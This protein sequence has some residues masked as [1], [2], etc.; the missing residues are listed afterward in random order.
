MNSSPGAGPTFFDTPLRTARNLRTRDQKRRHIRQ[1]IDVN[2]FNWLVW[3]VAASGFFTDSYNLFATNVILPSLGFVYWPESSSL[4]RE[5]LINCVTLAGA[6]VGQLVFGYLADRYGRTRLY[7]IELVIVIFS[8]IGV[9]SSATGYNGSMSLLVWFTAWRFVMGLGI[10]AEYPLSAVITAEWAPTGARARMMAAVFL[11]QPVGQL[12]AQLSGRLRSVCGRNMA[13]GYRR[14]RDSRS[15][16]HRVSVLIQDPGLY[17][18]DVK[19]QGDRALKNTDSLYPSA[20]NLPYQDVP[21]L[22][23][24]TPAIQ[25]DQ[26]LPRQFSRDDI[27]DYFWKQGNWRYLLGTSACWFLVDF[28]FFG[29]GIGNPRTL[30]KIWTPPDRTI[31]DIVPTWV[32]DPSMPPNNSTSVNPSI[33]DVLEQGAKQSIITV[34]IGSILGSILFIKFAD[35]IPRKQF[36]L[37][38]FLWL[39]V[40]FTITG[41]SFFGLFRT[42]ISAITIILIAICYFSF[43]LGA[44]TLTFI[45][46]AEIFPTRYRCT[47]HGISA[48]AGKLG[49]VFIQAILPS[50]SFGG[51]NANNPTSNL[52]GVVFIIFGFIMG[53]GAFFAWAWIPEV[54]NKR[55]DE[56]GLK[57]PSKTL[58]DLGEGLRKADHDGQ[59]IGFRRKLAGVFRSRQIGSRS[60]RDKRSNVLNE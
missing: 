49:S 11:M 53:L 7:G 34:S 4:W 19:N 51:V 10:G 15:V 48:A 46:P 24:P 37:W 27:H 29:L 1:T 5:T 30:A 35:Y 26:A 8:T 41:G 12:V 57:L 36:L 55:D 52:L 47:C 23:L 9:A 16:S 59:I 14:W 6:A 22:P 18:L 17:D 28:A 45:I 39:A 50:M 54:Q 38:S 13:M 43:N 56:G 40:L 3:A 60:G 2:G 42:N 32:I 33:F 44:N 31:R 21:L 20:T 58:E 25:G